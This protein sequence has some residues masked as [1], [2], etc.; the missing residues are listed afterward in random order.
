[1]NDI[2]PGLLAQE[3]AHPANSIGNGISE[4]S[5]FSL[6][7]DWG[8][9]LL[10]KTH[11]DSP[12]FQW[13]VV[14]IREKADPRH[15][16]PQMVRLQLGLSGAPGQ[17]WE[18]LRQRPLFQESRALYPGFIILVDESAREHE[19]FTFGGSIEVAQREEETIYLIRS[20]APILLLGR[21]VIEDEQA[22]EQFAEEFEMTLARAH[23]W[24]RMDD[25]GFA[26][27]L[28][29]TDP[30]QLYLACL[31][32]ILLKTASHGH[33]HTHEFIRQ[34]RSEHDWLSDTGRWSFYPPDI[35]QLL[36]P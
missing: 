16:N 26:D 8:Y 18:T 21:P 32:E 6:M 12:G 36:K 5:L 19:F 1:M 10:P 31:N 9:Y 20:P 2:Q 34:V 28:M 35:E 14:A 30:W 23:A 27:K 29:K 22:S 15:F 7:Q 11:V 33:L 17:K 13:L 4:E 25:I 3:I 24:W